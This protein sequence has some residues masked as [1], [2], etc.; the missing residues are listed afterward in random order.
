MVA[1]TGTAACLC[2][3]V[4]TF[5]K[6][7]QALQP[8]IYECVQQSVADARQ[9][10]DFFRLAHGTFATSPAIS[11]DYAVMEKTDRAVV[12]PLKAGWNDIGSWM[13]LSEVN[14]PDERGN[15]LQGDVMIEDVK[16]CYIRSTKRLVAAVG[17]DDLVIVE[18][19]D[20]VMVSQ[21][22]RVQDVKAVVAKLKIL[23]RPE[24]ENHLKVHR[25]WGTYET[26]DS[27]AR[28]QVKRI[29]STVLLLYQVSIQLIMATTRHPSLEHD[30]SVSSC[31]CDNRLPYD[32]G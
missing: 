29:T 8:E 6:E 23:E 7:L 14:R 30:R 15:V 26:V 32:F 9:D 12:V 16:D 18:T 17:V 28:Y 3:P 20:A 19:A 31:V 11:I 27:S 5:L 21:K 1:T 4:D 13:A 10:Q 2:L 25:P 24:A 22:G